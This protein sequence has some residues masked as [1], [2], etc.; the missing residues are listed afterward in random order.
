MARKRI[1][2]RGLMSDTFLDSRAGGLFLTIFFTDGIEECHLEQKN[3]REGNDY[4]APDIKKIIDNL[5][6]CPEMKSKAGKRQL[7]V[8]MLLYCRKKPADIANSFHI[9]KRTAAAVFQI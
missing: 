9:S 6:I 1:Y 3:N 5:P 8:L 2:G 4:V 7:E